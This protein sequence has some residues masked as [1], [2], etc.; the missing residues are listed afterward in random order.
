M[1][2]AV[3]Q[4]FELHPER[5]GASDDIISGLAVA[6]QQP[7]VL[8]QAIIVGTFIGIFMAWLTKM[9][10]WF[11][12]YFSY[13]VPVIFHF[14]I[15]AC[16]CGGLGAASYSIAG[17]LAVYGIGNELVREAMVNHFTMEQYIAVAGLKALAVMFCTALGGPGGLLS[18]SLII[19]GMIGGF[20]GQFTHNYFD[21]SYRV[22]P[23]IIFGMS[24]GF[25]GMF[26]SPITGIILIYE[27]TGLY[28]LV[29]PSMICN[30]VASYIAS[31]IENRNIYEGL[32]RQDHIKEVHRA[33]SAAGGMG[34][35]N[36]GATAVVP[37]DAMLMPHVG[38]EDREVSPHPS[39]SDRDTPDGQRIYFSK[40]YSYMF[41]FV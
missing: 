21:I 14:L 18:P 1:L 35:D 36:M 22:D 39:G 13:N 10:L 17:T 5:H 40:I 4:S 3:T 7:K 30:F 19:G 41:P 34:F 8:L 25:S 6:F 24:A 38:A 9:L 37:G 15:S 28:S 26:R 31:Y 20:V 12:A 27:L 29:L 32:L 2:F 11:R 23:C 33:L 16:I